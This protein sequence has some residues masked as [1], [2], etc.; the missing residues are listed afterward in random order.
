M[1]NFLVRRTSIALLTLI[2]LSMIAFVIIQL[3]PGDFVDIYIMD[4]RKEVWNRFDEQELQAMEDRL[5]EQYGLG[6][7]IYIQYFKWAFNMIQGDFGRSFHH[8]QPITTIIADKITMTVVLALATVLFTWTLAIPI[9]IYSAV[10]QRSVADYSITFL[11]FVGLAVPD[12]M[13]A[14]V[15]LYFGFV[16]FDFEI[17]GL[18]SREYRIAPWSLGKVVNLAEHL[19]IPV[20]ILGT[21]GTASLIR[22]LRANLLDE[23]RKPYVVTARAKGLPELRV[24]LKYPVRVALNPLISTVGYILPFLISGSVIVSVVLSLPTVGPILLQ[25]TLSQ[26]MFLAATIIMVLGL[27]T[28]V[29]TLISDLL[30]VLL[31]PRIRIEGQ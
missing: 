15:M 2:V 29:G 23:L 11:G 3:P 14:L 30:L 6:Q 19:W 4:F 27:M 13:L 24:I 22:I 1:V 8:T 26:D 31:D 5:R 28:V 16:W 12:F 9:G 20:I 21:S 7:P 25:S 17:G 18:F 10:R